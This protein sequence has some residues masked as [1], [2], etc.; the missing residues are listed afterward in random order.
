MVD[1]LTILSEVDKEFQKQLKE[2][3]NR[4]YKLSLR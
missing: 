4:C 1:I 2:V 3:I